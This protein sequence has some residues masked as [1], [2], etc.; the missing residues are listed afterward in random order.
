M[1]IKPKFPTSSST[2]PEH[3]AAFFKALGHPS[4]LMIL[5]LLRQ[6]S[7]HGEELAKR[8]N[9]SPATVSHHMNLLTEQNL[10]TA[11]KDQYWQ[12]YSLNE[13]ALQGSVLALI[14]V[15]IEEKQ[16]YSEQEKILHAFFKDGRLVKFPSQIKKQRIVLE[17]LI[18]AFEFDRTYTE[19]E[20]NRVLVEFNEDVATL[21]RMMV[22][23][24][25]M[26]RSNSIYQRVRDETST[27]IL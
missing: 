22:T 24:G 1:S 10:V 14:P 19:L 7:Q 2:T 17:K 15:L 23:E 4:R 21:R 13:K 8:L 20:V 11:Q 16:K 5:A 3:S 12:V 27:K 9:L 26:V 25:L 6:K 18:E